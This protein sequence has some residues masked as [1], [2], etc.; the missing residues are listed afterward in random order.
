VRA[1][2]LS[3]LVAGAACSTAAPAPP[4]GFQ[5]TA[6]GPAA[7]EQAGQKVAYRDDDA[8]TAAMAGVFMPGGDLGDLCD[9]VMATLIMGRDLVPAVS[10]EAEVGYLDAEG[11]FQANDF[12][13]WA[14]PAF[15][16]WR[17]RLPIRF[18]RPY[19]GGGLGVLYADYESVGRYSTTEY[20][21]A[22]NGF[23]GLEVEI[24][25]FAFG[26]EYKY[27]WAEE[28]DETVDQFNIEGQSLTA[29]L[30]LRF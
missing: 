15:V 1:F 25:S 4:T 16:N 14:I 11:P 23:G 19:L 10:V 3:L 27:V 20:L 26:A 8:Y 29:F 22:W 2:A 13:L 5:F 28:S 21:F 7:A 24:G 18:V 17:F 6:L 30:S 9:G 12:H